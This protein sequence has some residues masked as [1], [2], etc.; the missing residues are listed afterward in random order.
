MA[1][2]EKSGDFSFVSKEPDVNGHFPYVRQTGTLLADNGKIAVYQ[3]GA[4]QRTLIHA[5][6]VEAVRSGQLNVD[7]EVDAMLEAL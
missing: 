6:A 4:R 5:T 2:F 7:D 1:K 3:V